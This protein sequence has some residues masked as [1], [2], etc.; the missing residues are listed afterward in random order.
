MFWEEAGTLPLKPS[1]ENLS[2]ELG[3]V[4]LIIGPEGGFTA[5]EAEA[6]HHAGFK[7]CSLGPRILRA[8]TAALAAVTLAQYLFGDWQPPSTSRSFD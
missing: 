8:E 1:E 4:I 6:A 2:E 7:L 5:Q 3:G